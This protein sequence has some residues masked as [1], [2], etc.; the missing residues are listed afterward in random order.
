MLRNGNALLVFFAW[1]MAAVTALATVHVD[2]SSAEIVMATNSPK[3]VAFAARELGGLLGQRL[4]ATIPVVASPTPGKASI[5]LGEGPWMQE[6]GMDVAGLPH[7]AF[8]I[9]TDGTRVVI[10]GR[11][12]PKYDPDYIFGCAGLWMQ[13]FER[14]TLFGVYEFLER[15]AGVRLYFPGELGTVVPTGPFAVADCDLRV[16]PVFS[17]RTMRITLAKL[18]PVEVLRVATTFF[19]IVLFSYSFT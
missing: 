13:I 17:E 11:D 6:A 9:K 18:L 19:A 12:D 15:F 3:S 5:C 1:V 4:G 8:L 16:A 14:G 10:A 2:A 7:D